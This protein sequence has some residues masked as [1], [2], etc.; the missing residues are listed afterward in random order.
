MSSKYYITTP[1]YYVNDKPHIGH[2]Y[3]TVLAD[4]LAR[5]RRLMGVPTFF[6]TG[7]DEHG[8]KVAKAAAAAGISPQE[9][10]DR[11]V[12][13]FQEA[14]AKLVITND[15]FIRTTETRHKKVV[16][17]CLQKLW[18]AGEIY[19]TEYDGWYDVTSE[20]FVME[21]DLPDG[22]KPEDMPNLT[23][24]KESNYFFRMSKYQ[25]WLIEHINAN[26][27]FIQ[28]DFRRNETL[29]FLRK[30]LQDLCISRP[31]S[32]L[33][34]GIELPFDADYVCYVWFDALVNYITGVGY[35]QDEAQFARWWPVSCHLIGKDILTTHTVYWPTMLKALGVP[36]PEMIFAHGWWLMGGEK[37]AK[38][39]GNVV[40]PLEMADKYGVDA[41]RYFLIAEMAPG[42]DASF[43]EDAFVR[44]F[45]ADLA[46]DLGNLLSRLTN[47]TRRFC[48]G[49]IPEPGPDPLGGAEERDLWQ[50]V[51]NAVGLIEKGVD[52]MRLDLGL[53]QV[54]TAVKA[55]NRYFELK[56]PWSLGKQPDRGPLYTTLYVAAESL[57]V[58]S[59]LLSPVMPA[60]MEQLRAA[61]GLRGPCAYAELRQF[62]RLPAGR[63]VKEIGALFPRVDREG[64]VGADSRKTVPE[65]R[66]EPAPPDADGVITRDDFA[67]VQLR[68][69]KILQAE[70][71]EGA[72]K[73]LKL[74]VLMGKE[75]RQLVAG[76]ALHYT[77]DELIGKTVVVVANLKPAT[78]RGVESNGMLL[79]ASKGEKL[80]V[81]TVDGELSSGAMVK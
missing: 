11:T 49:K 17:Q 7:T 70:K 38:S 37:M 47:M 13:R 80:R 26:P 1:I 43:S 31:K 72:D 39:V 16:Q 71:I 60:K 77:P 45:N 56:Q 46:N 52:E 5:Y 35:L 32:R 25:Q 27:K 3:T 51:Q 9:Q 6:L 22:R 69:A 30:P 62:G 48:D 78:I 18:D 44:R 67:K 63:E 65:G 14:W 73:L 33:A 50:V 28:P 15:S 24:I 10:A 68:T 34:W 59:Q 58:C 61:L 29:G 20:T 8:Q 2:A 66:R 19:K 21:K 75:K 4:V 54:M 76:I 53:A 74:H 57:R 23:R 81:I 41:F 55:V 64:S 36:Q 79:A 40:N 12:V 42:Q